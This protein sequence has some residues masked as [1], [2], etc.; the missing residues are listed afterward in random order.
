MFLLNIT[1]RISVFPGRD[2]TFRH[3][4]ISSLWTPLGKGP[5]F[6]LR[7]FGQYLKQISSDNTRR[8]FEKS[9]LLRFGSKARCGGVRMVSLQQHKNVRKSRRFV[10][11]NIFKHYLQD[12]FL[13]WIFKECSLDLFFNTKNINIQCFRSICF[14][15]N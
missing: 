2:R 3:C 5:F 8:Y 7:P 15:T 14:P 10:F 1:L 9:R 6:F 11:S 4:R 12:F 13:I